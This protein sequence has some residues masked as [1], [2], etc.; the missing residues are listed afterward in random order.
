MIQK[1]LNVLGK[2]DAENLGKNTF[3]NF[4]FKPSCIDYYIFDVDVTDG[5]TDKEVDKA[6][7]HRSEIFAQLFSYAMGQD[8]GQKK[9]I[10]EKFKNCY[11][12]IEQFFG[13][14]CKN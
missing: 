10:V 12:Y 4:L 2:K 8:D 9:D 11:K 5:V 7:Y 13:I 14:K 6:Y 1:N 3:S